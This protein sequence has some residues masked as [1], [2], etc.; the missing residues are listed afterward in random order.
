M[1][2]SLG[3]L[4]KR[5]HVGL[6][7]EEEGEV[8][9]YKHYTEEQKGRNAYTIHRQVKFTPCIHHGIQASKGPI[10][11]N[12]TKLIYL[13]FAATRQYFTFAARYT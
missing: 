1:V 13:T 11:A 8:R 9:T 6:K 10:R 5:T 4:T 12:R 2:N 3:H 7:E